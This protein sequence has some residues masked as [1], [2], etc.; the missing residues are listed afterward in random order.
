MN[1]G[2]EHQWLQ[3]SKK[4]RANQ[5]LGAPD[6][7]THYHLG[8]NLSKKFFEFVQFTE[9]IKWCHRD[10]ISQVQTVANYNDEW[11]NLFNKTAL[12]DRRWGNLEI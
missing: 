1:P 4:K 10:K 6:R 8:S 5:R 11:S 9:H 12:Q 2:N 3:I 7:S